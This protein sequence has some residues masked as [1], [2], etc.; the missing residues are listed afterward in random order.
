MT[1]QPRRWWEFIRNEASSSKAVVRIYGEITSWPWFDGD[2]SAAGLV[3]ALE[4]AGDV[5]EIELHLNS[6]GGEAFEGVAIM[7]AL[8]QHPATVTA[9]VDGMAASA[10]SV[11]AMGADEVV[12]YPGSQLMIHDAMTFAFGFADD[13]HKAADDLD[14]LSDSM[15]SLYADRAG[16]TAEVWREVMKA[17]TWYNGDEAV[18]AGLA[19][20]VV[21]SGD[22]APDA[23][24]ALATLRQSPVAA[25]YRYMGRAQAPAPR[26]PVH[27]GGSG[28]EGGRSVE[29]T[30]EDFA[31]LRSKLGLSEDAEI[32]DV[33]DALDE[34]ETPQG[35]EAAAARAQTPPQGVLTIDEATWAQV[36]ADARLGREAAL[37]QAVA[38]REAVLAQA[39]TDGRVM[40]SR[41]DYWRGQL[42]A[43]EEGVTA[44][45][46]A[47]APIFGTSELGHDA[48]GDSTGDANTLEGVRNS[49][50]YKSWKV[51]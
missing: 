41:L 48:G 32:G 44:A 49:D 36:Q 19:D 2:M 17:E 21:K 12:M 45:I 39:V 16:G 27:A 31:A 18:A 37:A 28:T 26:T 14:H 7:N 30:D 29:I 35:T 33:L 38:R 25:C 11:V 9:H 50:E 8:R 43:D 15:A 47:L 42:E 22:K 6:P 40:P 3:K 10:A 4:D 24:T 34:D 51:I 13:L 5:S 20:R 46:T 1:A 23:A